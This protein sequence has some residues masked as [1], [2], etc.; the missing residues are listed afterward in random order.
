MN[1]SEIARVEQEKFDALRTTLEELEDFD[2]EMLSPQSDC[3]GFG[4]PAVCT[5]HLGDCLC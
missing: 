1:P 5:C 3:S 2:S 4:P